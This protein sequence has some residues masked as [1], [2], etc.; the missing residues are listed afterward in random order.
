GV[1]FVHQDDAVARDAQV[2][3]RCGPADHLVAM[4]PQPRDVC[5]GAVGGLEREHAGEDATPASSSRASRPATSTASTAT[6]PASRSI[7]SAG[8]PGRAV[9]GIGS[10]TGGGAVV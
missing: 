4:V 1:G 7:G 5:G 10:S 8:C 3:V 2:G 6:D 9:A